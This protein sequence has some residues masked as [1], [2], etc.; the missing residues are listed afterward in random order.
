MQ[1]TAPMALSTTKSTMQA[2]FT[3][4]GAALTAVETMSGSAYATV[5]GSTT[6]VNGPVP[7]SGISAAATFTSPTTTA[8]VLIDVEAISTLNSRIVTVYQVASSPSIVEFDGTRLFVGGSSVAG[9]GHTISADPNGM[10]DD[11]TLIP[12]TTTTVSGDVSEMSK[13]QASSLGPWAEGTTPATT[14]VGTASTT[15]QQNPALNPTAAG[16]SSIA[17]LGLMAMCILFACAFA[18]MR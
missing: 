3:V 15:G 1:T 6:S 4:G 17:A 8:S 11:G 10:I 14:Q 7:G 16:A 18:L 13:L 12:W 2:V 5:V 9:D